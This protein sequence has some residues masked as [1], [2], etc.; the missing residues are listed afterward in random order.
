M[1]LLGTFENVQAL[2][3]QD[4]KGRQERGTFLQWEQTASHRKLRTLKC[5]WAIKMITDL[6]KTVTEFKDITHVTKWQGN[7]LEEPMN[8]ENTK[9]IVKQLKELSFKETQHLVEK[10]AKYI[11]AVI[12]QGRA[13]TLGPGREPAQRIKPA[14]CG[15]QRRE[16]GRNSCSKSSG[17]LP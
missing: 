3:A 1:L 12:S 14:P 2:R 4:L 10:W 16:R 7:D 6:I 13:A 9:S 11:W 15:Q 17:P 8:V 5:R